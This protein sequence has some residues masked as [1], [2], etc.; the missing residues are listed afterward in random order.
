MARKKSS[1][2]KRFL[3]YAAFLASIS[4]ITISFI[5]Y[6]TGTWNI[7]TANANASI[8]LE[9]TFLSAVWAY[10]ILKGKTPKKIIKELGLSRK[11]LTAKTILLGALIFL[12]ILGVEFGFSAFSAVTGIP[13]PT[14]VQQVLGG[15]P[16][17]FLVFSVV[18]TP[19]CEETLFRG[20]LTPRI[21]IIIST[22]LFAFAHIGYGSISEV[23]GA[24]AFG[25]IAAFIF[26]K[27]KSLYP[28]IIAHMAV[29]ALSMAA[30]IILFIH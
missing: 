14:N 21:G 17:Y 5:L 22:L 27:Y 10:L 23:A 2:K 24:L 1:D 18:I 28:S 30:L 29:N 13:L 26:K 11:S 7:N 4:L 12:I 16:L 15:L 20:F 9:L 25:L 19:I 3:F 6:F 8:G